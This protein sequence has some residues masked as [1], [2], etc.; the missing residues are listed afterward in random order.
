MRSDVEKIIHALMTSHVML[1]GVINPE[2]SD[3]NNTQ[4]F[5]LGKSTIPDLIAL[6]G[7]QRFIVA[8]ENVRAVDRLL[9]VF[10]R[11]SFN[12]YFLPSQFNHVTSILLGDKNDVFLTTPLSGC[13]VLVTQTQDGVK[14]Y[15]FNAIDDE[16]ATNAMIEKT[17]SDEEKKNIIFKITRDDYAPYDHNHLGIPITIIGLRNEGCWSFHYQYPH[18]EGFT[19]HSTMTADEKSRLC[20]KTNTPE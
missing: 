4:R 18:D 12:A 8:E 13:T 2:N 14:A 7:P 3:E 9:A 19:Y 5:V 10:P 17:L 1:Y 6:E 16:G 20:T 15:H 11:I